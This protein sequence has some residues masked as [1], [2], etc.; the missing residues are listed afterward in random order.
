MF[1]APRG[2]RGWKTFYAILKGLILYLQKVSFSEH[3]RSVSEKQSVI[4]TAWYL[5]FNL[6]NNGWLHF[7]KHSAWL[8]CQQQFF[9]R[10]LCP[11]GESNNKV[12]HQMLPA[13]TRALNMIYLNQI[14]A[15]KKSSFPLTAQQVICPFK[16]CFDAYFLFIWIMLLWHN[17]LMQPDSDPYGAVRL[18]LL[19]G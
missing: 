19:R 11:C 14:S 7:H 12:F 17:V 13:C 15:M 10:T 18:A 5:L 3:A 4:A 9:S 1:P 8:W 6:L 16:S 2:K